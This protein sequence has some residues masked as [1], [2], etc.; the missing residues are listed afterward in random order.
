[1]SLCVSVFLSVCVFGQQFSIRNYVRALVLRAS[2]IASFLSF[3]SYFSIFIHYHDYSFF[4][5]YLT[6]SIILWVNFPIIYSIS[7]ISFLLSH[8]FFSLPFSPPLFPLFSFLYSSLFSPLL[9]PLTSLLSSPNT[10]KSCQNLTHLYQD[11]ISIVAKA[12][13]TC[14]EPE[15]KRVREIEREKERERERKKKRERQ[16]ERESEREKQNECVTERVSD[17]GR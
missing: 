10:N 4:L 14:S 5:F 16:G 3:I 9:S 7:Q 2:S 11:L 12:S 6:F 1:M 15:G 13:E 17:R 8:S